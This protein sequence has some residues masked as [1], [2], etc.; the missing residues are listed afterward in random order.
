[1]DWGRAVDEALETSTAD[2][3]AA[4]TIHRHFAELKAIGMWAVSARILPVECTSYRFKKPRR[5]HRDVDDLPTRQQIEAVAAALTAPYDPLIVRM[6]AYCGPRIGELLA[7]TADDFDLDGHTI[8]ITK[9]IDG[10]NQAVA[11]VKSGRGRVV[12][13]TELLDEDIRT[14]VITT[15]RE[16]GRLARVFPYN[17]HQFEHEWTKAR[18][19]AGWTVPGSRKLRW[20]FHDLRHFYC[21]WALSKDGLDLGVA[22]VSKIAGHFSPEF[23]YRTYVRSRPGLHERV[24]QAG[25]RVTRIDSHA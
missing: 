12:Y 8:H 19:K 3:L 1:M 20:R 7:L 25:M 9:Q 5:S 11:R 2:G 14:L 16:R 23:T 10:D 21:S 6:A 18:H 4:A 13:W 22:D 17:R 24:R 15:R